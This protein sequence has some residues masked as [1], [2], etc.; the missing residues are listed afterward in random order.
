MHVLF[1]W[2]CMHILCMCVRVCAYVVCLTMLKPFACTR[3]FCAF[4]C[5]Y[6][7]ARF[8]HAFMRVCTC[9]LACSKW[10]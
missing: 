1:L 5:A 6:T 9:T 7:S 3:V 4:L 8:T 2:F 10:T